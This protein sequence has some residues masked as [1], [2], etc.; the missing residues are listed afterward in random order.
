MAYSYGK[1]FLANT[2]VPPIV[3]ELEAVFRELP[4]EELLANLRGPKRRGR[5]GYDSSILWRCY[6]AYYALGLSSVSDLIRLLYDNPYITA[7]CG[8]S[9]PTGIPSQPTFSRF[10][11]KLSRQQ[12]TAQVRR[13]FYRLTQ[14][15]HSSVPN[16]GKSVAVDATDLK[17]WS[18]GGHEKPT[19]K[20]A[21]WVIK[22]DTNGRGKFTWGYK[23]TLLVDTESELPMAL[24]V[25]SGNVHEVKA[26]PTVLHQVRKN[27]TSKFHP[28][29]V[30]GDTAYSS[31]AFRRLIR[32]QYSAE[33]IIKVNP[34]HKRAV[35]AYPETL[36][37]QLVYNRRTSAERL[38]AR[39][40]GY[41]K[42][43]SI[44]VRGIQKVIVHCLLSIIVLQTQALATKSRISVRKV[45]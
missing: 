6:V 21:G 32:R 13:I 25:T 39:L 45:S 3:L 5:R 24:K 8:I 44:R 40:K 37:W 42:L 16:F 14:K 36:E 33:P 1:I 27:I 9:S 35:R 34:S 10:F 31:E 17:A 15:L 43:N 41:R 18:N 29:Y 2:Q 4:D 22:K 30:I 38:F 26:A 28:D 19:D 11:S 12:F 23:L 7:A 20:D